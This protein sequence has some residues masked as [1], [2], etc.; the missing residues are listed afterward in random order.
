M[1]K[2]YFFNLV[3]ALLLAFSVPAFADDHS[4]DDKKKERAS[5]SCGG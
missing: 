2:I 4:K 5:Q 1:K 3:V